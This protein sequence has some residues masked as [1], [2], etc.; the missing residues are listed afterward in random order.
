M[1]NTDEDLAKAEIAKTVMKHLEPT[2]MVIKADMFS[3]IQNTRS[4]WFGR[5]KRDEL[6]RQ[7][8]SLDALMGVLE[9]EL[10]NGKIAEKILTKQARAK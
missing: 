7:L 5:R 9:R 4:G 1:R 6:H 3:K 2:A 10:Q 8:N